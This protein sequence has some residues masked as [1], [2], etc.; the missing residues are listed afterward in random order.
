MMHP[1]IAEDHPVVTAGIMTMMENVPDVNRCGFDDLS[2]GDFALFALNSVWGIG[3]TRL[4][5]NEPEG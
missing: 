3:T 5:I 2:R 4:I 1:P